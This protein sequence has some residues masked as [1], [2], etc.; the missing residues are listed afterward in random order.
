MIAPNPNIVRSGIMHVVITIVTNA[1]MSVSSAFCPLSRALLAI[2]PTLPVRSLAASAI[3]PG[4]SQKDLSFLVS[5]PILSISFDISFVLILMSLSIFLTALCSPD[6]KFVS[7]KLEIIKE[8][9]TA[10]NIITP[11]VRHLNA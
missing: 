4:I 8:A 2:C 1:L 11:N 6:K 10:T 9:G 3:F 5:L 7:I